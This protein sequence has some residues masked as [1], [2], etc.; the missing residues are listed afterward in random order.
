MFAIFSDPRGKFLAKVGAERGSGF[1]GQRLVGIGIIQML[2][3]SHLDVSV[4]FDNGWAQIF[5]TGDDEQVGVAFDLFE[6]VTLVKQEVK[7]WTPAMEEGPKRE[8]EAIHTTGKFLREGS[9][10]EPV[11]GRVHPGVEVGS[12]I[13]GVERR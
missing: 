7:F 1:R 6:G 3:K 5:V 8:S 2:R 12:G 11:G 10:W 9:G 4:P 13:V